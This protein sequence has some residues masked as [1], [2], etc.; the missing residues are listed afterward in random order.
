[1][2]QLVISP[3]LLMVPSLPGQQKHKKHLNKLLNY[4]VKLL[5]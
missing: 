5:Y 3:R 1:L 2:L 4:Y